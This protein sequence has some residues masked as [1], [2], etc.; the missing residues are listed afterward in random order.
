MRT[1]RIVNGTMYREFPLYRNTKAE[2]GFHGEILDKLHAMLLRTYRQRRWTFVFRLDL[3]FPVDYPLQTDNRLFRAFMQRFADVVRRECGACE[4]MW[5]MERNWRINPHYHLALAVNGDRTYSGWQ[6]MRLATNLW[7]RQ[8]AIAFADYD[9]LVHLANP[10]PAP[11]P[12]TPAYFFP[13][14]FGMMIDARAPEADFRTKEVF[15][16][17]SYLGKAYSKRPAA[18]CRS[19]GTSHF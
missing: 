8:L 3:T 15:E 5:V 11:G 6:W 2:D 12:N 1:H 7:G 14:S 17:I 19:Y 10:E 18:G 4:Y 13:V 9:G 16:W